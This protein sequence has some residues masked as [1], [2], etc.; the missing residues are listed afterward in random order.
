MAIISLMNTIQKRTSGSGRI[1]KNPDRKE[2]ERRLSGNI[3]PSLFAYLT[4][5]MILIAT[6]VV[7]IVVSSI[8]TLW[9]Y[10]QTNVALNGLIIF[11][12]AVSLFQA[13]HNNYKLY[14]TAQFLK[15]IENVTERGNASDEEVKTLNQ[16]LEN[17]IPLLN[18]KQMHS[19]IN[20]L[21]I[22]GHPN[23]T[24]ND[25]RI[26]KSKL[27]AR[28]RL[29]RADVG[30]NAGILVML[31]LL[32]TFLGLLK[33]IDAV[34][35]ALA[36]MSNLGGDGGEITAETMSTFISSLSA[37]LQGMGLAFSS[38][39]FGLSGSLLI[40]FFNHLCGG[41]QDTFIE[42]AS[43]WVDNRIPQFDPD[44]DEE[45]PTS[46]PASE[47]D[48]RTW[49]AGFVHL[50]V[51]TN[52]QISNLSQAVLLS[53]K[54]SS[55][56]Y[57]TLDKI[58]TGQENMT[59][60]F[61]TTSQT[62]SQTLQALGT[63]NNALIEH[64]LQSTQA[65]QDL[66][67]TSS[68]NL[69]NI[70][71][72]VQGLSETLQQGLN[73][74][75]SATQSTLTTMISHLEDLKTVAQNKEEFAVLVSHIKSVESTLL[76]IHQEQ[77]QIMKGFSQGQPK[78]EDF[79]VHLKHIETLLEDLNTKQQATLQKINTQTAQVLPVEHEDFS[80]LSSDVQNLLNE[81]DQNDGNFFKD[82]LGLNKE[83]KKK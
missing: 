24:D 56:V 71:S 4:P 9:L 77:A 66:N 23:F 17:D 68:Q 5:L 73:Q 35:E 54:Q 15:E 82:F 72:Q 38:S 7:G 18:T 51:K 76:S 13:F 75:M 47:D 67:A 30:F 55:G 58:A 21:K 43:R 69:A 65:V 53:L 70:G 39:L 48:L 20:N 60:Q 49:L 12:L 42:A 19:N 74:S 14:K 33:T 3:N 34:G 78:P 52:K 44:K 79:A 64:T 50:S 6:V 10:F 83:P 26:I 16:T 25:A 22:F 31:G 61:A 11:L 46:R 81:L 59:D 27:G 29:K 36:G 41:S 80:E 37:P 62:L 45:D 40:G 57:S 1:F 28:I 8:G 32:G 63:Q 2:K